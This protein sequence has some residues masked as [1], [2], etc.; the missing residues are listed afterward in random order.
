MEKSIF[1]K[2]FENHALLDHFLDNMFLEYSKSD[3]Y[4][5]NKNRRPIDIDTELDC[6]LGFG[7]VSKNKREKYSLNWNNDITMIL[8]R[9]DDALSDID[10]DVDE[11]EET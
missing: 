3:L 1:E 2:L 6:L 9:L 10:I 8:I 5:T 7:I 11:D 4:E